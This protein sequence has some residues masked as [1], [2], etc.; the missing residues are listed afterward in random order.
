[1]NKLNNII[2]IGMMGSGKS[3]IAQSLSKKI[4][5]PALDTDQLIE[6]EYKSSIT[7]IINLHGIEQFRVIENEILKDLYNTHTSPSIIATGGGIVTTQASRE[8]LVKLGTVVWLEVTAE[9]VLER[10]Q[11]DTT[12]PLLQGNSKEAQIQQLIQE[13]SEVYKQCSDYSLLVDNKD[14]EDITKEIMGFIN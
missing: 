6:E 13:R 14:I 3:T 10:L 7:E 11:G 1:M 2:L 8:L 4:N 9:T 12:R 5:L